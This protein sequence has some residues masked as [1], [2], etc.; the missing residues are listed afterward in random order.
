ML[1]LQQQAQ[2]AIGSG[3]ER[4]GRAAVM[5]RCCGKSQHWLQVLL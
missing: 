1:L 2:A 5:L 3:L 4:K